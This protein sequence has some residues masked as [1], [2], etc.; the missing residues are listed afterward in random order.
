MTLHIKNMVCYR[1]IMVVRQQLTALGFSVSQISLGLAVITPAPTLPQIQQINNTLRTS[2]LE[3]IYHSR[4]QLIERIKNVITDLVDHNDFSINVS[5]ST[6][7]AGRL[8]RDYAYLSRLFSA[9]EG[10]TIEHYVREQKIAKAKAL[11]QETD[12][13]ITEIA[14]ALGYSSCAHLSSQFKGITGA[15]PRRYKELLLTS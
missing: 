4:E 8:Q 15:S 2:G 5:F 1:C 12:L 7:I 10:M 13:N 11:L 14:Y 3:L 9:T 6:L